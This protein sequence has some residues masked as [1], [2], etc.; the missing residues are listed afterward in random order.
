LRCT[1]ILI[2]AACL[3]IWCDL[4]GCQSQVRNASRAANLVRE[5]ARSSEARFETIR[6]QV[7]VFNP[8]SLTNIRSEA[9]AGIVEQKRIQALAGGIQETLTAV[10]DRQSPWVGIARIWGWVAAALIA[11]AAMVYFGAGHLIRRA[12]RTTLPG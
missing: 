11:L 12:I 3:V 7:E 5:S 1:S 4:S 6:A 10:E 2:S 9:E 8:E